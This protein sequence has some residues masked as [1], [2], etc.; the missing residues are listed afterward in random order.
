MTKTTKSAIAQAGAADFHIE[1]FRPSRLRKLVLHWTRGL[2]AHILREYQLTM[3]EAR[4]LTALKPAG[5]ASTED[6]IALALVDRV[7]LSRSLAILRNAK[8]VRIIKDAEDRRRVHV[9]LT[10]RGM[11]TRASISSK[12]LEMEQWL[13]ADFSPADLKVFD[14][15]LE[16]LLARVEGIDAQLGTLSKST[17]RNVKPV[18]RVM[19]RL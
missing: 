2:E 19:S 13:L 12:A 15:M 7:H 11:Q 10:A 4:V 6:L 8:L 16:R 17:S 5:T 14:D 3:S 9:E 1:R 18:R